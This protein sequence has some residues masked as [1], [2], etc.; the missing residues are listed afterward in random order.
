MLSTAIVLNKSLTNQFRWFWS[1][2]AMFA[3]SYT[4][5]I[6]YVVDRRVSCF[7]CSFVLNFALSLKRE[8][9]KHLVQGALS[10]KYLQATELSSNVTHT[11]DANP[12]NKQ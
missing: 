1:T 3:C 6:V 8:V 2:R 9:V 5:W 10:N 11:T 4:L 7:L 12:Q